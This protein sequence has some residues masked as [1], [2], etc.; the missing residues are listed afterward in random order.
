MHKTSDKS[1]LRLYYTA[2]LVYKKRKEKHYSP[3]NLK[4]YKYL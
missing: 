2:T 1:W 4:H 3:L